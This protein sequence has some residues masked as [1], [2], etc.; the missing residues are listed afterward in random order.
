MLGEQEEI[1]ER[2]NDK[3]Q[4]LLT[5]PF[6]SNEAYYRGAKPR[7]L[8]LPKLGPSLR[9]VFWNIERG[10]NTDLIKLALTDTE[11]FLQSVPPN[12]QS[13]RS[14]VREQLAAVQSAD[15]VV[16]NEADWGLKRTGYR[17]VVEELGKALDMNWAFGTEFVEVDSKML[18]TE[19]FESVPNEAERAKFREAVAVDPTRLRA[20]HGSAVLSRYPI[21]EARLVPFREPGY[22]WFKGEKNVSRLESGKR[23]A[24]VLLG[25]MLGREVREAAERT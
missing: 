17:A 2:L 11:A 6:V 7:P 4:G 13:E 19:G 3:L 8:V 18:G 15:V 21:R 12:A 9:V 10:L 16:V 5:T 22:D 24:A 20:L 25:E 14:A 1:D 23:K